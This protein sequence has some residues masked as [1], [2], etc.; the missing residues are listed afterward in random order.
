MQLSDNADVNIRSHLDL[1]SFTL[2]LGSLLKQRDV[3]FQL[4]DETFL[5][6]GLSASLLTGLIG[7]ISVDM[8]RYYLLQLI[9]HLESAGPTVVKLLQ[10]EV[11]SVRQAR[12]HAED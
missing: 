6:S 3:P 2:S 12:K 9:R 10:R 5:P 1:L 7:G 8:L 4:L 11:E